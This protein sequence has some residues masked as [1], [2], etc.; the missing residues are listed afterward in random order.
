[1]AAYTELYS[2]FVDAS[3]R[4]KIQVAAAVKAY[5]ILQEATPSQ[6]RKDWAVKA[7]TAGQ[8]EA[9]YLLRYVLAAN[10]DLTVQLIQSATD[11]AIQTQ[12]AAAVDKLFT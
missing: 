12:V 4:N 1:M 11:A 8:G 5:Q 6:S 7:M 9:D 2:L 3:L 10:K